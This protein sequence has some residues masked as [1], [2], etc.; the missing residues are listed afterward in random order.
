MPLRENIGRNKISEANLPPH[1][2]GRFQTRA[3][4]FGSSVPSTELSGVCGEEISIN[5]PVGFGADGKLYV[6]DV[7]STNDLPVVGFAEQAGAIGDRIAYKREGIGTIDGTLV[8]GEFVWLTESSPYV[9]TDVPTGTNNH[10]IQRLGKA[11]TETTF[12][13]MI[14]PAEIYR[15]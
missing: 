14:E 12:L 11:L 1:L 6:A 9:S 15:S 3:S 10:Y 13:I 8:V 2:R 5:F 7:D 4:R